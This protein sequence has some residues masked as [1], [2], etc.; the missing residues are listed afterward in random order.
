MTTGHESLVIDAVTDEFLDDKQMNIFEIDNKSEFESLF[1]SL[2]DQ[3]RTENN[4]NLLAQFINRGG[5]F[6]RSS[7]EYAKKNY[8]DNFDAYIKM[9]LE[10]DW[11]KGEREKAAILKKKEEKEKAREKVENEDL[12]KTAEIK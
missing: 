6:V 1:N 8:K 3:F 4:R 9:T 10:N 7:I 11:S 12:R 5:D 2:P